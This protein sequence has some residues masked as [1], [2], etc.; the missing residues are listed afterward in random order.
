MTSFFP[1]FLEAVVAPSAPCVMPG[2]FT[3][4]LPTLQAGLLPALVPA[5]VPIAASVPAIWPHFVISTLV[6]RLSF[7][8]AFFVAR[9]PALV[10][11]LV[12]A[13]VLTT[14]RRPPLRL[15]ASRPLAD[16]INLLHLG[17]EVR[18]IPTVDWLLSQRISSKM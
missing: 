3:T 2:F 10:A 6:A 7:R 5:V 12:R 4:V 13:L 17:Q 9:V 15:R 14:Q 18:N 11:P 1:A 8:L 16:P